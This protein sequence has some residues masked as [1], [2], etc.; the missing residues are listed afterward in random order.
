MNKIMLRDIR[1]AVSLVLLPL[2][3]GVIFAVS[4]HRGMTPCS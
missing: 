4:H 3:P 2:S 1:A